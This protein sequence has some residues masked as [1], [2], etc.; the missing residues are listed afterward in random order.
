MAGWIFSCFPA[1]A[2]KERQPALPTAGRED[3]FLTYWG[4]NVLYRNN[5]MAPSPM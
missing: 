4:H 2:W 5:G 3:L 1:A